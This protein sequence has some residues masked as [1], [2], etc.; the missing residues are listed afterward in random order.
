MGRLPGAPIL[1]LSCGCL[2][3]FVVVHQHSIMGVELRFNSRM[4]GER[5]SDILLTEVHLLKNVTGGVIVLLTDDTLNH[6]TPGAD[7]VRALG[8]GN[9]ILLPVLAAVLVTE[10]GFLHYYDNHAIV[11]NTYSLYRD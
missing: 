4:D 1:L 5:R 11:H 2:L 7:A 9:D 10:Y 6:S 3:F 8:E